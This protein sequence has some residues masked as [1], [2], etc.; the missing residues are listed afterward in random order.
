MAKLQLHDMSP[1]DNVA[2]IID[3]LTRVSELPEPDQL[4]FSD[5]LFFQ[6]VEEISA[7]SW[8]P[9]TAFTEFFNA[10]NKAQLRTVKYRIVGVYLKLGVYTDIHGDAIRTAMAWAVSQ[11]YKNEMRG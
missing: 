11:M 6:D 2:V 7:D 9:L 4:E 3:E 5:E 1:A 8:E 10:L